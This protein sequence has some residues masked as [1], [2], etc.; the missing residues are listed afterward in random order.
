MAFPVVRYSSV[1]GSNTAASG[2]PFG[3][4]PV[5]DVTTSQTVTGTALSNTITFSSAVDLTGIAN[6]GSDVIYVGHGL[7]ERYLFAIASITGTVA[8]CTAVT[9]EQAIGATGLT[10]ESWAIGGL[11]KDG[12]LQD[13]TNDADGIKSVHY[14]SEDW[15][16][17]WTAEFTNGETFVFPSKDSWCTNPTGI[18]YP[19]TIKAVDP[20]DQ[21]NL[22]LFDTIYSLAPRSG[23]TAG[24]GFLNFKSSA[25]SLVVVD[26]ISFSRSSGQWEGS[27]CLDGDGASYAQK[28][29]TARLGG[30][31][32]LL[33]PVLELH[34]LND[35]R[36]AV[37]AI[38][39]A[40][41]FLG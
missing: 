28:L 36:Q 16:T 9:T 5:T 31:L 10:A 22:P 18:V 24:Y 19:L 32:M 3:M 4:T 20:S 27:Y 2:A 41:F 8:A 14:D 35:L 1:S 7:D 12:M 11:R 40:P 15:S 6:D 34:P 30:V 37:F 21:A 39:F 26:G 17:G 29:V 25:Y 23:Y 33:D 38:E 13:G